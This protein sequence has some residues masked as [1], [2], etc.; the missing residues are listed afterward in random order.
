MVIPGQ[1]VTLHRH[2]LEIVWKP[3]S[4]TPLVQPVLPRCWLPSPCWG[5]RVEQGTPGPSRSGRLAVGSLAVPESSLPAAPARL[6]T[7]SLWNLLV[8]SPQGRPGGGAQHRS[9]A[10]AA[11]AWFSGGAST[12][13][14]PPHPVEGARG[15]GRRGHHAH[16]AGPWWGAGALGLVGRTFLGPLRREGLEGPELG[17][18]PGTC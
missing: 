7:P 1:P 16:C 12:P 2:G 5:Q 18:K 4:Y 9:A 11:P 6:T 3:V 14:L 17:K 15:R 10:R 8:M 13:G